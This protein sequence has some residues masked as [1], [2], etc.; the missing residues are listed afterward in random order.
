MARLLTALATIQYAASSFAVWSPLDAAT[1]A[2]AVSTTAALTANA[3]HLV[4]AG[5]ATGDGATHGAAAY[6]FGAF[7]LLLTRVCVVASVV[8]VRVARSRS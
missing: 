6:N 3:T 8:S 5:G 1:A 2:P 7:M 4:V